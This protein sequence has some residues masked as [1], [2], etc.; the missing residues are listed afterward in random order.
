MEEIWKDIPGYEGKYQ[1]SNEGRVKSKYHSIIRKQ[2]Q[3]KSGY[4][5]VGLKKNGK[6][7]QYRVNRLVYETFIGPIPH[8]MHVNHINEDKTDNRLE[9]LCLMTPKE[10][11]NWG[12]RNKKLSIAK[13]NGK[14]S[15]I[16]C[17]YSL[18]G[19]YVKKYESVRQAARETGFDQ[20]F[21]SA[22]ARGK[23]E[24]AYGYVW[25]YRN[26]EEILKALDELFE[27]LYKDDNR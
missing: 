11:C 22:C 18:D 26:P 2:W 23:Y 24:A 1:V 16:I 20:G 13:T 5:Y 7:S 15:K 6:Q 12:A 27:E 17:Q 8:S 9:N 4:L 19:K 3:N 25:K 21:L 10:N 14:G